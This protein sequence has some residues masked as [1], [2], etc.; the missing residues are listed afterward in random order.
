MLALRSQ[1]VK[2]MIL[3][4]KKNK[5]VMMRYHDV[6]ARDAELQLLIE[7]AYDRSFFPAAARPYFRPES[8]DTSAVAMQP[9]EWALDTRVALSHAHL[10]RP[11]AEKMAAILQD[12]GITQ[13]AGSGYGS[14]LL[15]G[16]VLQSSGQMS[17]GLIREARKRYGFRRVIEGDLRPDTPTMIVDDVVSSGRHAM[18]AAAEMHAEGL[19]PVGVL[20][21]FVY[22]WRDA[23]QRLARN[24]LKLRAL[25]DINVRPTGKP[26]A[27]DRE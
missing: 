13:I 12:Q 15:V 18:R 6:V 1:A 11:I 3:Q 25:A 5:G 26:S 19:D 9:S 27:D 16:A 24:G 14:F 2:D 23:G 20:S 17:G 21:L 22:S 10:L 7:E 4:P 8:A